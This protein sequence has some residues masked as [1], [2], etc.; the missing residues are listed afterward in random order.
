MDSHNILQGCGNPVC[1]VID[2]K[3]RRF[4]SVC[5][6]LKFLCET[7]RKEQMNYMQK[8]D[9]YDISMFLNKPIL[10]NQKITYGKLCIVD[11]KNGAAEK[12]WTDDD[13]NLDQCMSCQMHDYCNKIITINIDLQNVIKIHLKK[14]ATLEI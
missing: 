4:R 13:Q 3:P 1:V 6:Y 7:N 2:S 12:P 14:E 8:G 11:N 9:C 10:W 5:A